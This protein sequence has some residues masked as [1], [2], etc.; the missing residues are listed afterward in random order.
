MA[1]QSV[2]YQNHLKSSRDIR[3]IFLFPLI[4]LLFPVVPPNVKTIESKFYVVSIKCREWT[5]HNYPGGGFPVQRLIF[6][7]FG[8]QQE[9]E[10]HEKHPEVV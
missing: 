2:I 10:K 1:P 5:W 8:A 3:S 4:S 9:H 6:S 7:F